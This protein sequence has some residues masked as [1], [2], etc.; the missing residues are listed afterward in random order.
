M[1][2]DKV[3]EIL[4]QEPYFIKCSTTASSPYY[5]LKST[6]NKSDLDNPIV[7]IW[8]ILTNF[9]I[10]CSILVF[11]AWYKVVVHTE[12]LKSI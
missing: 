6:E 5:V 9:S 1:D 10:L 8:F 3:K 7:L 4:K 2:K 11:T 12:N